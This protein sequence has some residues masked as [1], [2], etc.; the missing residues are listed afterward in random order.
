MYFKV[1]R[2]SSK[3]ITLFLNQFLYEKHIIM[4]SV[5]WTIF[6][7]EFEDHRARE[8]FIS[9]AVDS[10]ILYIAHEGEDERSSAKN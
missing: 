10:R 7:E 8:I 9:I 5:R 2:D 4:Y 1:T 6:L 3:N